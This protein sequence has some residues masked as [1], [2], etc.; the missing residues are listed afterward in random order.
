[1]MYTAE[2]AVSMLQERWKRNPEGMDTVVTL[3]KLECNEVDG[4]SYDEYVVSC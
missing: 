3:D 2:C 4:Q 1:M